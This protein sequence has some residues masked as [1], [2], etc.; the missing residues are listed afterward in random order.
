MIHALRYHDISCGHRVVGHTV[1]E[2]GST[3][4]GPCARIHGHNYRI[5][6]TVSPR[7]GLVNG[8]VLDFGLI[9]QYLDLWLDVH[10]DHR[11]LCWTQDPWKDKLLAIDPSVVCVEFNPTAENIGLYLLEKVGPEV[12][13][14]TSGIL[15]RCV[16][17]ETRKCSAEV[18]LDT[19]S[20]NLF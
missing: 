11:F 17:E 3:I 5:H 19:Y 7:E 12:L 9:K 8:M 13:K 20:L 15:T 1:V 4:S 6:F 2:N 16:V 18:E 14:E 10:W